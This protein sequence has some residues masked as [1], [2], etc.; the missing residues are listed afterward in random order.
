MKKITH[1]KV[2]SS[3]LCLWIFC[4]NYVIILLCSISAFWVGG[5]PRGCSSGCCWDE[6]TGT[7]TDGNSVTCV[8]PQRAGTSWSSSYQCHLATALQWF[9]HHYFNENFRIPSNSETEFK[10]LDCD[11]SPILH[12]FLYQSEVFIVL[13]I[14][15][16]RKIFL[17]ISCKTHWAD[18]LNF[19]N[20]EQQF[21]RCLIYP[22][23]FLGC[24]TYSWSSGVE[25]FIHTW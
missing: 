13:G 4:Y 15:R 14:Y 12:D 16:L 3:T 2:Q 19:K 7:T 23:T 24:G 11:G 10:G 1:L 17:K 6:V 9:H 8:Q 25:T 20:R 18:R 5:P 21:R 22:C